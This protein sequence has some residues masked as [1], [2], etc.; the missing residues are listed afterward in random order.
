M[1]RLKQWCADVNAGQNRVHYD[2]IFVDEESFNRYKPK[3]FSDLL[4]G[5]TQYKT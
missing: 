2:F 3:T 4:V 1:Q 5:F